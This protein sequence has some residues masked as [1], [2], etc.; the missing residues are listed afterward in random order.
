MREG[1]LALLLIPV[2]GATATVA[3]LLMRLWQVVLELLVVVFV[4]RDT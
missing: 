4:M 1:T 2:L 3:A